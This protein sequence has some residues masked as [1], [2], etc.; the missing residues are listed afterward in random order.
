MAATQ[1]HCNK[2]TAANAGTHNTVRKQQISHENNQIDIHT[3][4]KL[5]QLIYKLVEH[6]LR[7]APTQYRL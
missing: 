3:P 2:P 7:S 5:R 1:F 6:G 4:C